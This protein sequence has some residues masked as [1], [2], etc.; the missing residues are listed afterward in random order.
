M[1]AWTTE[2][3]RLASA[4]LSR[5]LE[6]EGGAWGCAR[7][8]SGLHLGFLAGVFAEGLD[9]QASNGVDWPQLLCPGRA[10][11]AL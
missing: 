4:A 3:D 2:G 1:T 9:P 5:N 11:V 10:A 8:R 6:V 7:S